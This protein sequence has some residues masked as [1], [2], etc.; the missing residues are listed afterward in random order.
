MASTN[1]W[2]KARNSFCGNALKFDNDHLKRDVFF[3][4]AQR[5]KN[6]KIAIEKENEND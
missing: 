3:D 4:A 2:K 1:K 5:K 6:K